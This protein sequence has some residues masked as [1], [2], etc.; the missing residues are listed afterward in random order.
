MQSEPTK[1]HLWLQQLV[2]EWTYESIEPV[3]PDQPACVKTGTESI[4]ALGQYWVIAEGRGEGEEG[5]N[6]IITL[7]YDP[8]KE[9]FVGFTVVPSMSYLWPYEGALDESGKKLILDSEGPSFETVGE[10]AKYRDTIELGEN[11]TRTF[12]SSYLGKDGQW[13]GFM[14]VSYKRTG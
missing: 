3:E 6:S 2:G 13:V 5:C 1:E 9:R 14:D 7:G 8:D 4:R 12:A 11:G 10:I